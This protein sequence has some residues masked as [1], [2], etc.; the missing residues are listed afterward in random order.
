VQVGEDYFLLL[1][2]GSGLC[3]YDVGDRVRVLGWADEAPVIEFLS[4]DAHTASMA[5]EKLTED[6]VVAAMQRVPGSEGRFI[7]D[8]VLAPRWAEVP[9]YRVYVDASAAR[10]VERLGERLD[11]ALCEISV[12]YASK[13]KTLR[14]RGVE[15][16]ELPEGFLAER[17]L[18]LRA[19][20]AQTSEQ[21]K[22]QYL[23]PRPGLDDALAESARVPTAATAA[24]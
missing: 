19:E 12:E 3:R 5:G 4:R 22:H 17:D 8:F 14:L 18:A 15:V 10:G 1:T 9:W 7:A 16:A 20:R 11:D 23:I 2:N 6:Q 21:F 13:R 24:E